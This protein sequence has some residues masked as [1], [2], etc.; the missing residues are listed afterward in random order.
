MSPSTSSSATPNG[1]TPHRTAADAASSSSRAA[2]DAATNAATSQTPNETKPPS[3]GLLPKIPTKAASLGHTVTSTPSSTAPQAPGN[4]PSTRSSPPTVLPR[5]PSTTG[6]GIAASKP[7]GGGRIAAATKG[8]GGRGGSGRPTP[9]NETRR[10]RGRPPGR[11][12]NA[13]PPPTALTHH[14]SSS[15]ALPSANPHGNMA[16][17]ASSSSLHALVAA[18]ESITSKAHYAHGRHPPPHGTARTAHP[19]S[20]AH[21]TP[22]LPHSQPNALPTQPQSTPKWTH[23][24]L[25]DD[26]SLDSEYARFVRSLLQSHDDDATTVFTF[27]TLT[28]IPPPENGNGAAVAECLLGTIVGDDGGGMVG[29]ALEDGDDEEY[30][31]TS[32]EEEEEDDDDEEDD[33][34]EDIEDNSMHQNGEEQEEKK[35]DKKRSHVMAT[36]LKK[37]HRDDYDYLDDHLFGEIEGLMEED[38]DA[39]LTSLLHTDI[40]GESSRPDTIWNHKSGGGGVGV[41]ATTPAGKIAVAGTEQQ[42]AITSPGQSTKKKKSTQTVVTTPPLG[43]ASPEISNSSLPHH[44]HSAAAATTTTF[45]HLSTPSGPLVT[46]QQLHRLRSTM[47]K[48]HQLL[49]QQATLAVRAAY[50]QKVAKDSQR[51]ASGGAAPPSKTASGG[52]LPGVSLSSSSSLPASMLNTRSL[53]FCPPQGRRRECSYENDFYHGENAEELAE[54]LDGAVGML[55]DLEQNWKD[56]VRNSIQL[57]FSQGAHPTAAPS[58]QG[59]RRNLLSSMGEETDDIPETEA[60]GIHATN[61][62]HTSLERRL[63]RSA[64]TKTL[65]EREMEMTVL[66][67]DGETSI[68]PSGVNAVR[69]RISVF[70]IRGLARLRE[71]FSAIDNSVN[72]VRM[73]ESKE[74]HGE[75][76]QLLL[77]HAGAE[78]D[79]SLVPGSVDLGDLLT[80]A[81]EAFAEPE[82][83]NRPLTKTQRL[84]LRKNKNQF[85]AGEDN[86]ILRGVNLYGEKEWVLVS[87]R[88]LP[89]R[90]VNN[91]S[92]RYHRL[93][94][95]IYKSNGIYIDDEGKLAPLPSFKKGCVVSEEDD[96]AERTMEAVS[97]IKPPAPPTTMNVHRWTMEEDIAI[98]KAVPMMGN[99][100]AEICNHIIPHRDRGHIRK[101]YQVLERRIP[102]GTTKMN[103]KRPAEIELAREVTKSAKTM[104]TKTQKPPLSQ[105]NVVPKKANSTVSKTQPKTTSTGVRSTHPIKIIPN[106]PK[107]SKIVE[108]SSEEKGAIALAPRASP[109]TSDL[110]KSFAPFS[111]KP[112]SEFEVN[113]DED[114]EKAAALLHKLSTPQRNFPKQELKPLSQDHDSTKDLEYIFHGH[115][116]SNACETTRMGL[117]KILADEWSQASGMQRLLEAGFAESNINPVDG[118]KPFHSPIKSSH[119]PEMEMDHLGAS[120]LSMLHEFNATVNARKDSNSNKGHAAV[121]CLKTKENASKRSNAE[122]LPERPVKVSGSPV[123]VDLDAY[124]S[125]SPSQ[126]NIFSEPLSHPASALSYDHGTLTPGRIGSPGKF[127]TPTREGGKSQL[128]DEAFQ[129]FIWNSNKSTT[130]SKLRML[131]PNTPLNHF[132]FS[133]SNG[134]LSGPV[135]GGNNSLLMA[136]DDFDAVSALQDLSNSAPPTPSKLLLP[137]T[138]GTRGVLPYSRTGCN[139]V[140]ATV[141]KGKEPP[142]PKTSF[143]SRVKAKVGESQRKAA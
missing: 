79:A 47:A 139:V 42:K 118:S 1:Q 58:Q 89:D 84:E 81:P 95:L 28:S 45:N 103:L 80:H 126:E 26:T 21:S 114:H 57:S 124:V 92:Q 18:A 43:W 134:G 44:H 40:L 53:T 115:E 2:V 101:R 88:F 23:P 64:F 129:Y 63:T 30:L 98:L 127:D 12:P 7:S 74:G 96:A 70:D 130:P 104:T 32:E 136:G 27:K 37:M 109:P 69:H 128:C 54:C 55:Q 33:M 110:P 48:H 41:N 99:Q 140:E 25:S 91:I 107:S 78:V 131:P 59:G 71:T 5:P 19:S 119:L 123:K 34:D 108:S 17:A 122:A 138:E 6:R 15:A 62:A 22:T 20:S 117:E 86:L 111:D 52:V 106:P 9:N 11:G 82:K 87:D 8:R 51:C 38:L 10:G 105:K 112:T 16:N 72:E 24:A 50:V 125:S 113:I 121:F 137:I 31:L 143:L 141:D 66:Q 77:K 4:A 68:L 75:A 116:L 56:A 133:F 120:R 14:S 60:S 46:R 93:C 142:K 61:D 35:D 67:N 83:V 97:K 132:G 100:W 49:L 135:D 29:N 39:Q 13:S 94:F 65:L 90:P 73:E 102:K 76:C 36:P 85:T 3:I